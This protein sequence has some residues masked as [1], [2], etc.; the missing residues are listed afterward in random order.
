MRLR[1]RHTGLIAVVMLLINFPL[2]AIDSA[3][4]KMGSLQYA[5]IDLS[6]LDIQF[7]LGDDGLAMQASAAQFEVAGYQFTDVKL[8]CQQF[9]LVSQ[10]WQCQQ[11]TLAFNHT[12][13]GKQQIVL[14]FSANSVLSEYY[15]TLNHLTLAGGQWRIDAT[16]KQQ[17][18]QFTVDAEQAEISSF[19]TL[20][21]Q[22]LPAQ[23]LSVINAWQPQ[24]VV[25]GTI[26]M[27][28][29]GNQLQKADITLNSEDFGFSDDIGS[30][31]AE[32]LA[33]DLVLA[34]E[35]KQDW[36][37]QADIAIDDGQS[38]W[39]PVF[40]DFQQ[41]P[42]IFSIT[43]FMQP[44]QQRWQIDNFNLQQQAVVAASG[45]LT[46]EEQQLKAL[47]LEVSSSPLA[48][49]YQWWLQP[50]TAGTAAANLE[51][52]GN[53]GLSLNWQPQALEMQ[54]DLQQL[55]LHD[56]AERF[57]LTGLDGM[58]AWTTEKDSV[59]VN[60]SWQQI[61]LGALPIAAGQLQAEVASNQLV[62]SETLDLPVLDG[63]LQISDFNYH[64]AEKGSDWQFQGL[65]TPVS[66]QALTE[67]FGW[68][69]MEGKLSGVIP[70]VTYR[71]QQIDIAG[72][73]QIKVFDGTIIL[74]DLQLQSP[75]GSLPQLTANLDL[76]RLDLALLTKT[77]DFG[78][79][80]GRLDG[81]I[82]DLRLLNWQPVQFDAHF[83]TSASSPGKRRISQR[84]VD[85]L[86]QI[87]G[88]ASGIM[89]RSFLRFFEDFSYDKLGISCKLINEIC[90][91]SGVEEDDQGYYIVKGG[92]LP[93]W[94][95]V[96]G[97][98]R[99]VDWPELLA[100]LQA[101]KNSDG[102]IIE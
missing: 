17:S 68:P 15:F 95:N 28:G 32:T 18:W 78:E 2:Q 37:F 90:H 21:T 60:V 51:T 71:D 1:I 76:Q 94:I 59:P 3:R 74:K 38:Y 23:N 69:L 96:M 10:F 29:A 4:L 9:K 54:V 101:V 13:M 73:L 70:E 27:Q 79:I 98:T 77:F 39:T 30:R 34:A 49:I 36:Q 24:G 85:N 102:P 53:I 12:I 67:A 64:Y 8:Q 92:G 46:L 50:F 6:Q 11:G 20:I 14:V 66:M 33:L 55:T 82:A 88:G 61:M 83:A 58:F 80:S 52:S 48:A 35:K 81:Q 22:L 43:G 65:L 91:M 72:A 89:S 45:A 56:K 87:G 19:L 44:Q 5:D 25:T 40:L 99:R 62:L 42:F 63:A 7:S 97:Y 26:A 75:F 31:V 47:Q 93:P 84:A 86:S 41:T 16:L 100:R 57:A